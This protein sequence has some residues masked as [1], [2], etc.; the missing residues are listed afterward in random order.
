MAAGARLSLAALGAGLAAFLLWASVTTHMERACTLLDTPYLPLC[1]TAPPPDAVRQ[2]ALRARIAGNP[3]DAAAWIDLTALETGQHEQALLQAASTLAPTEPN[4]LT[5]RVGAALTRN[6]LPKATQL[7]VELV[8]FR[9]NGKAAQTLG[10]IVASGAGTALLRPHLPTAPRWLP[11]V[12]ASMEALKLPLSTALPLV[13]AASAKGSLTKPTIQQYT[14]A[15]KADGQWGDAYGLWVARQRRATPLL[16]NGRFDQAFEPD[17]FDWEVTPSL[18]SR[19][20]ALVSQRGSGNRG[21]V[22]DIQFTGRPVALPIIR[23]YVFAAPGK[24]LL[25]G[26]YMST[27]LRTEQGLA[28]TARCSNAKAANPVAGRSTGL[29]DTAGAWQTFQFVIAIP[30]DCG[31]VT[32][33]QLETFAPF[34]AAAGFKGRAAFDAL[35]LLPQGV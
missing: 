11:Q 7:L 6:D 13:A 19:A 35:E 14:R 34:E 25:R 31:P 12:L 8:E 9:G 15:L 3:G 1:P 18:P 24:Y 28:W 29:Q 32:S 20:G 16:Y 5:W 33:L 27:R 30:A 26:Q 21:Q 23:Q 10:R 2:E 4:V 17:G 22:L